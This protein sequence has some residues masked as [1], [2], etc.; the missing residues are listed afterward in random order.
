[1]VAT[2]KKL[3]D[4][5]NPRGIYT[6]E[7][8]YTLLINIGGILDVTGAW[9]FMPKNWAGIAMAI[10]NGLYAIGRGQSKQRENPSG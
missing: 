1:M 7:F 3:T 9:T 10:V 2:T 6:T 8:W 4:P 5:G